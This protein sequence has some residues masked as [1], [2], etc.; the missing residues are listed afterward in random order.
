MLITKKRLESS[1]KR[2]RR[3]ANFLKAQR[4]MQPQVDSSYL[5]RSHDEL[6]DHFHFGLKIVREEG[7]HDVVHSK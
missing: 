2:P 7:K 3:Q 6:K 5:E 1:G 4:R